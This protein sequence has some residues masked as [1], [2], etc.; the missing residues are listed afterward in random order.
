MRAEDFELMY[1]LEDKF[2]W[3]VAMRKITDTIVEAEI[4]RPQIHV[5][6]AGCGTGY[7]LSHYASQDSRKVY[8]LDIEKNAIEWVRKRGFHKIAQASVTQIPFTSGTFDLVFSFDVL[9]QLPEKLNE[10][11]IR[12]MHRVLKPGGVLFIRVAAFEW[13]RSSHD[14][15]LNT[16]HRFSRTELVDKLACCGFKVEWQ[17]YANSLLLPVVIFRRALKSIGV[18]R[19]TN[20]RPLPRGLG[21]LDGVFRTVLESEARWFK[22]G[23]SLPFGLS[24]ICYAK[25]VGS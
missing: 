23:R 9:Q 3:F 17:S 14:E 11:A 6:D 10:T 20:V 8:G 16:L 15:E 25:K 7:N 5:L 19:G 21:W 1:K 22:S 18:G 4:Q 2:W 13:L 24:I 12:E